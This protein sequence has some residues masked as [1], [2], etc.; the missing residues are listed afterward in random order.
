MNESNEKRGV[1]VVHSNLNTDDFEQL[2]VQLPTSMVIVSPSATDEE[3]RSVGI[4]PR[5]PEESRQLKEKTEAELRKPS[6]FSVRDETQA[7]IR[8]GKG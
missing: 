3:L 7:L 2:D 1:A 5:T 6:R 4:D 8:S